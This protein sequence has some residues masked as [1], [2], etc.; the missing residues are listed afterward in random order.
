MSVT[1]RTCNT[2]GKLWTVNTAENV[3]LDAVPPS[4]SGKQNF[5]LNMYLRRDYAE[6]FL[7]KLFYQLGCYVAKQPGQWCHRF[8]SS[9]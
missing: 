5:P 9:I 3:N 2:N 6:K 1:R 4:L 8:R 7:S